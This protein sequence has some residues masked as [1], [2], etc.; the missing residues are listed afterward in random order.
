M[1]RLVSRFFEERPRL[2]D[3]AAP[4]QRV[5][6]TTLF[7]VALVTALAR[8][9]SPFA[10][11]AALLPLDV[12]VVLAN[13][14]AFAVRMILAPDSAQF[15]RESR[16]GLGI[17]ITGACGAIAQAVG[18]ELCHVAWV[19]CLALV[20]LHI[21]AR[22]LHLA[23]LGVL[24]ER[25]GNVHLV[26]TGS[27]VLIIVIGTLLLML[28]TATTEE[29]GISFVDA[30][31]T[32]TS[33]TC[34]T[35]LAVQ[36]TPVAFTR[37]GHWIL[38]ALI[39]VGGL[40]LMTMT[41]FAATT[42]GSGLSLGETMRL[43]GIL[44]SESLGQVRGSLAFIL[45]STILFELAGVVLLFVLAPLP[46]TPP[47]GAGDLRYVSDRLFAAIF[48][49]VSAFCNAG[50]ALHSDSLVSWRSAHAAGI[51]VVMVLI[52]AGGLGFRVHQ[53]LWALVKWRLTGRKS[54]PEDARPWRIEVQTW[55]VLAATGTLLLS[56]TIGMAALET[57][58]GALT[59]L[60]RGG[61]AY[62]ALFESVTARTAGFNTVDIAAHTD[63]GLFFM[64][65]LMF[66]GASPGSTGGGIKTSTFALAALA[67]WQMVTNSSQVAV[68]HRRVPHR[69]VESAL[70]VVLLGA[71]I[72]GASTLFLLATQ[73]VPLRDL[74]FES[75][76]AFATVGLSTGV[77]P[78]LTDGGKLLLCAVMLVGRIGPL[79]LML[80]MASRRPRPA[81]EYPS[82]DVMVG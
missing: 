1:N 67:L 57:G 79:T 16:L 20:E 82:E 26:L 54:A 39:Q 49:A 35:G 9:G 29:L 7:A 53:D 58:T 75:V 13:F 11:G 19:G 76:S 48:H 46:G 71:I 70:V 81:F 42:L 23:C 36:D 8:H 56:G 15:A 78:H 64:I 37:L 52:V 63:A 17:A 18:G 38:L 34:V 47:A 60:S 5:L 3:R 12:T 33:A 32:A 69:A 74:L 6:E 65:I 40:G 24:G 41:A 30:L 50:F 61:S 77:T 43:K 28:P 66:I 55:I 73:T 80:A 59:D 25:R 44:S 22:G 2:R 45:Y 14:A 21:I 27:F 62:H 31:F 51:G 72:V 68:A 10:P 4:A